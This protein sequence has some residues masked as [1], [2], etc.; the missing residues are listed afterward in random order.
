MFGDCKSSSVV[1]ALSRSAGILLA[2]VMARL[3]TRAEVSRKSDTGTT[4]EVIEAV[5]NELKAELQ[6]LREEDTPQYP[7]ALP[8]VDAMLKEKRARISVRAAINKITLAFRK[9]T[10]TAFLAIDPKLVG[11]FGDVIQSS[12]RKAIAEALGVKE[13]E[14]VP[15]AARTGSVAVDVQLLCPD[16]ESALANLQLQ[17]KTIDSVL[18]KSL[19]GRLITRI[20]NFELPEPGTTV[21]AFR[22]SPSCAVSGAIYGQGVL[23]DACNDG[24]S[25]NRVTR[26]STSENRSLPAY[27]FGG[28]QIYRHS[29]GVGRVLLLLCML[30][31]KRV[32]SNIENPVAVIVAVG[33]VPVL[34]C[35]LCTLVARIALASRI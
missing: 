11:P 12:V 27:F 22:S 15:V 14:V 21:G 26:S 1:Y 17:L 35:S 7:N 20:E 4:A 2:E 6:G 8:L 5:D 9:K 13:E 28:K 30:Q 18:R 19:V 25:A 24:S 33:Y 10:I 34:K 23:R 32:L 29:R 16:A 31:A 3:D